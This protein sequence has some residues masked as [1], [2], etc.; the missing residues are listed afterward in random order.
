M[1]DIDLAFLWKRRWFV[2]TMIVGFLLMALPTPVG[3][4]P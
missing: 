1:G 4:H 3:P 2:I